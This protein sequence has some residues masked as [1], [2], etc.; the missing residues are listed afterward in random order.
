MSLCVCSVFFA[1]ILEVLQWLQDPRPLYMEETHKRNT[2]AL[3]Q[4]E[5]KQVN[6]VKGGCVILWRASF[7]LTVVWF[8]FL[9]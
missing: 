4:D 9:Q 8:V 1:G 7:R 2:A 5:G 6:R 3:V